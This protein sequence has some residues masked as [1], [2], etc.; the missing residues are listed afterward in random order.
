M[1]GEAPPPPQGYPPGPGAYPPPGQ[2]WYPPPGVYP[3]APRGPANDVAVAGF[4][5]SVCAVVLLVFSSGLGA[6]LTLVLAVLG[7]VFAR[8]GKQKLERGET[9]QNRGLAQAGFIVGIVGVGLSLLA[10]LFWIGLIILAVAA[11]DDFGDSSDPEGFEATSTLIAL[12]RA[13]LQLA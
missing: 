2:P 13:L 11:D 4:V 9:D 1:A 6:P 10:A 8:K 7:V 5:L 3:P 12:G